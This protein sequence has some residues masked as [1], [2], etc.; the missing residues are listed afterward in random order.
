MAH[1]ENILRLLDAQRCTRCGKAAVRG[2][3]VCLGCV[4]DDILSGDALG[5]P[6]WQAGPMASHKAAG[7]RPGAPGPTQPLRKSASGR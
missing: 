7:A 3:T 2:A 6:A 5:L 1:A 4:A